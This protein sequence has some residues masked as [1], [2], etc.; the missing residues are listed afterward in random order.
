MPGIDA[1][2]LYCG[3]PALVD[4]RGGVDE[5]TSSG[6]CSLDIA[7]ESSDVV[8]ERDGPG[9]AVVAVAGQRGEVA[10]LVVA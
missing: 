8:V 5:V 2:S 1:H 3:T 4:G 7:E 6:G 10:G 9:I